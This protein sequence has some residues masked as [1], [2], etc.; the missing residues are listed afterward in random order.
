MVKEGHNR[1]LIWGTT[2]LEVVLWKGRQAVTKVQE[3]GDSHK[4]KSLGLQDLAELKCT[5]NLNYVVFDKSWKT[6]RH[7]VQLQKSTT[8]ALLKHFC[9]RLLIIM[10]LN[11]GSYVG[12]INPLLNSSFYSSHWE[13]EIAQGDGVQQVWQE[14][15][16]SLFQAKQTSP[17]TWATHGLRVKST[18][19]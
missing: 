3:T 11:I 13:N 9:I 2:S 8:Q 1:N 7:F 17:P 6:I 4:A 18:P 15:K 16:K 5:L 14:G 10:Y 12:W 19:L